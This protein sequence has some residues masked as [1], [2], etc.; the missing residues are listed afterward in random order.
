M[1]FDWHYFFH[2]FPLLIKA[3]PLTL[4][5]A[6]G[7]V[8]VSLIVGGVISYL[9]LQ[10]FRPLRWFASIYVSGFRA[11]PAVVQIF[12]AYYGLPELIPALKTVSPQTIIIFALGFKYAA[13]MAETFRSAIHSV[14]YGQQE[15]AKALH[16][17]QSQYVLRVLWPQAAVNA[18]PTVGN[19][20]IGILKETSLVFVIGVSEM[21]GEGK[22][23]AG[24]SFKY[25]EV[26]VAV[27]LIYWALVVAYSSLQRA[28]EWRF[29]R[30]EV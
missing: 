4:Y 25:L 24:A 30:F 27:G 26:Y 11:V 28:V 12:L 13:Y 20:I 9:G 8:I 18:L 2:V 16:I 5:L 10:S 22:L 21:F 3:L 19:Y 15:A 7:I 6:V 29:K 14:D 1:T 23:L 17:K